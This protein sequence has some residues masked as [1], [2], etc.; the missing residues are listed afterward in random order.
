MGVDDYKL[1][2]ANERLNL[3]KKQQ[4]LNWNAIRRDNAS[5][6][7]F[8]DQVHS[9]R[10]QLRN[11]A[12]GSVSIDSS[13]GPM[14]NTESA[15]RDVMRTYTMGNQAKPVANKQA[16]AQTFITNPITVPSSFT[17]AEPENALMLPQFQFVEE[18]KDLPHTKNGLEILP[19]LHDVYYRQRKTMEGALADK[20]PETKA[21]H[22]QI[23]ANM[24][25]HYAKFAAVATQELNSRG[26]LTPQQRGA[27]IS[28]W[29]KEL[30][31]Q[32]ERVVKPALKTQFDGG[33]THYSEV[34]AALKNFQAES[35]P[36]LLSLFYD[37]NKARRGDMFGGYNVGAIGLG[38]VGAY[39]GF[40]FG[41]G[42]LFGILAAVIGGVAGSFLGNRG[43]NMVFKQPDDV[44]P[45]HTSQV[46][47]NTSSGPTQSQAV[48]T[49]VPARVT[50]A[51]VMDE[52]EKKFSVKSSGT[53][54]T[55][56]ETV[57]QSKPVAPK[58]VA[59][60]IQTPTEQ[61][62]LPGL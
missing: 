32:V 12:A 18:A 8:L 25:E 47:R 7:L 35:N 3:W 6:E 48:E 51:N 24:L 58:T 50:S 46:A 10:G 21:K 19:E 16:P 11:N 45:S 37:K 2:E 56:G 17:R 22:T 23:Y 43:H 20:D 49:T 60:P 55:G 40:L 13:S 5:T 26:D 28:Q 61:P 44:Y 31:S 38:A 57:D 59:A 53:T 34:D 14:D 36:G 9:Q 29:H 39:V 52:I 4:R 42:G 27:L 54:V 41:G 33:I 62:I 30:S 15:L 1:A